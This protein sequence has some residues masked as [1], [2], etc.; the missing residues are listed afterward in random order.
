MSSLSHLLFVH[1]LFPFDDPSYSSTRF[2]SSDVLTTAPGPPLPSLPSDLIYR[3]MPKIEF[4]FFPF[5]LLFLFIFIFFIVFFDPSLAQTSILIIKG[6]WVVVHRSADSSS[7][8]T[9]STHQRSKFDAPTLF[10]FTHILPLADN[11]KPC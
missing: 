6:G 7:S 3:I 2:P 9:A 8:L 1:D 11:L 10:S 5:F 4:N